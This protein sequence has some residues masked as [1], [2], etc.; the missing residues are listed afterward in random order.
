M[1][2][3]LTAPKYSCICSIFCHWFC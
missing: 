2:K 1:F 3:G